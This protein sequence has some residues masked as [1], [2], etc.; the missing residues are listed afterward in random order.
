MEPNDVLREKKEALSLL[1]EKIEGL[2]CE[3]E[4]IFHTNIV[5]LKKDGC[6]SKR[7]ELRMVL[8]WSKVVNEATIRNSKSD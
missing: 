5:L 2:I 4:K 3:F 1:E 6:S 7:V 8:D